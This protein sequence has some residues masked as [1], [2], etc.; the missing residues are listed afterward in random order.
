MNGGL[1]FANALIDKEVRSCD[2]SH[3][4]IMGLLEVCLVPAKSE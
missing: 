4:A 3:V 1:V 2:G